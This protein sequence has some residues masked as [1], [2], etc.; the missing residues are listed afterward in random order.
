MY[1]YYDENGILKEIINDEALR[2]FSNVNTLYMYFASENVPSLITLAI[3]TN[4]EERTVSEVIVDPLSDFEEKEISEY[5][6]ERILKYFEYGKTYK[7]YKY[8]LTSSNLAYSGLLKITPYVSFASG[9]ESYGVVCLNVEASNVIPTSLSTYAEYL[10]ILDQISSLNANNVKTNSVQDITATK[11]FTYNDGTNAFTNEVSCYGLAISRVVD[12]VR[13][14]Y[15]RVDDS[16]VI[17][18]DDANKL[19]SGMTKNGFDVWDEDEEH[20]TQ[21]GL[22]TITVNHTNTLTLPEKTDTLATVGDIP[23]LYRHQFN[24]ASSYHGTIPTG[25]FRCVITFL[26]S[27]STQQVNSLDDVRAMIE[28]NSGYLTVDAGEIYDGS[29]W[30]ELLYMVKEGTTTIRGVFVTSL[31]GFSDSTVLY[32]PDISNYRIKQIF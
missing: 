5:S 30:R 17:I 8:T 29:E 18:Q 19:Y 2:Q 3:Q 32:S 11:T 6:K 27:S 14:K 16:A 12:G 22:N 13:T 26:S 24:F 28:D 31:G 10:D 1:L 20:E 9:S 7:F 4:D 15:A 25:A 23:H 21:Y